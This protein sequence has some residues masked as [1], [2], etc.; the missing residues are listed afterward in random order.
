MDEA[1]FTASGWHI[2]SST[3][4]GEIGVR[5]LLQAGVSEEEAVR[6]A[7]GWG[8]DRAYLFEGE[9]GAPLF[10]WKTVWDRREDASEFFRAYS[11]L[12]QRRKAAQAIRTS[13]SGDEAQTIW[14]EDGRMTI[15][16]LSNESVLIVR[17]LESNAETALDLARR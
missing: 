14:R 7:A 6:A 16:Q 3:P 13:N 9:K 2:A 10:V 5:G 4:L 17:G 1:G 11:A 12:Q 8:G 15:V